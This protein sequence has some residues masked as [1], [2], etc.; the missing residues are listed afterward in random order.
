[1]GLQDVKDKIYKLYSDKISIIDETYINT[2]HKA[3]FIC[4]IHNKEF[5]SYLTNILQGNCAGCE[6]CKS[7]SKRKIDLK[8]VLPKIKNKHLK[9]IGH[10]LI[11]SHIYID[12]NCLNCG[13]NFSQRKDSIIYKDNNIDCPYC[14]NKKNREFKNGIWEFQKKTTDIYKREVYEL[15]G[16]EYEVLDEYMGALTPIHMKHNLC[17]EI[18]KIKPNNF[19][20]NNR[21]C[22]YCSSSKGEDKIK[23]FLDS[24]NISYEFQKKFD[25]LVG[26]GN[27]LLSYDFYI[28]ENNILIEFQGE[29]HEKP[30]DFFGGKDTFVIQQEHDKR[31]RE[32][33][34]QNN[35]KLLEIWYYDFDNIESILKSHLSL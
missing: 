34:E 3:S 22:P 14:G 17:G 9:V 8:K 18:W 5:N 10:H 4:N 1:M 16:D 32:Y 31:K 24:Y 30:K 26:V 21:R 27:G 23:S 13:N 7:E 20:S 19:L 12:F 15:V 29:Q 2:K 28:K 35:I 6:L 33:A 11:K 25:G